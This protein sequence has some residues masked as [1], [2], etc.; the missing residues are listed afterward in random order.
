MSTLYA[1]ST[2]NLSAINWNTAANGSGSNQT[3]TSADTLVANGY[4]VTLDADYTFVQLK[5]TS[6]GGTFVPASGTTLTLTDAT[7]GL[8]SGSNLTPPTVT[9]SGPGG[10]NIVGLLVG[11]TY[12]SPLVAVTGAGTLNVTT[13]SLLGQASYS[14]GA[15]SISGNGC[16]VNVAAGQIVGGT[17][18]PAILCSASATLNVTG[19]QTAGANPAISITGA[20]TVTIAG[21]STASASS[22]AVVNT[23]TTA[24]L[25]ASGPLVNSGRRMAIQSPVLQIGSASTYMTMV[26][27]NLNA[28]NLYTADTIG[29]NPAVG[30]VRHGTTF[31]PSN[32]LVGTCYVPGAAS[33]LAGVP[34]D[35][36]LGTVTLT[37]ADIRNAIGLASA[38]LDTQL[39]GIHAKTTNLPASPAAEGSA[40]T[41]TPAY[42]AAK[43]AATQASV[44]AIPTT[45]LLAANYT[46]P[47]SASAI[48]IE[49]DANSTKLDAAVST[50]LTVIAALN[51]FD[52]AADTVAHVTLVDTTTD[53]TNGGGGGGDPAAIADAV[54]EELA[55]ELASITSIETRLEEQVPT[56]PAVVIPAPSGGQ[57]TAWIMCYDETGQPEEG[58]TI[59][60]SCV[61]ATDGGAFDATPTVLTSDEN[62]LASGPIPRGSGLSFTARRGTGKPVR[63][64]G[65]DADTLALP[66]LL[67]TP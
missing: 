12:A 48:R 17:N 34:V 21:T 33:V 2:G 3:P 9:H 8:V 25:K 6:N 50:V 42:D 66:P 18:G 26:D 24:I 27:Y 63:F 64:V 32:E 49:I 51:D 65:V 58:T 62:G 61:R 19:P 13:A 10:A 39:S 11:T 38:D 44:N 14:T 52:P 20:A 57:T 31:G 15:L 43:T 53:L 30:N 23:S 56:G 29:G 28:R 41:L 40:M 36:T 47:P 5:Q 37:A 16:T 46:A 67:G 7:S 4:T 54:R 60:L 35:A 1:Q 55:P 45:P 22:P 59:T